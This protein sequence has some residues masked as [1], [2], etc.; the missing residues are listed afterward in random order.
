MMGPN[1]KTLA[2]LRRFPGPLTLYPS[3]TKWLLI[4]LGCAVFTAGGI[5][6]IRDHE[7]SGWFVAG[8]FGLGS[9]TSIVVMLPGAG[10]LTLD[11]KGFEVTNL[12]RRHQT[13]WADADGFDSSVIP[14]A[15]TSLVVYDDLTVM[16]GAMTGFNTAITGRNAALND[17]YGLSADALAE[18]MTAWRGR[19]LTAGAR[20]QFGR[21]ARQ[22]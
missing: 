10:A 9:L 6:M 21:A 17:T 15:H 16:P 3:K 19:A 4:L 2:L 5:W 7:A 13:R 22:F 1:D 8:F 11:Q 14:P 18:L 12:F 20:T